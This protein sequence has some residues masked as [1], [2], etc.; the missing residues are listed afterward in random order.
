MG[1]SYGLNAN[2]LPFHSNRIIITHVDNESPI[3]QFGEC[4]QSSF[5]REGHRLRLHYE[6]LSFNRRLASDISYSYLE[7]TRWCLLVRL[8]PGARFRNS[9]NEGRSAGACH[10]TSFHLARQTGQIKFPWRTFEAM[11]E[12]WKVC[13]HS[14]V[15]SAWPIPGF[16]LSR[17]IAHVICKWKLPHYQKYQKLKPLKSTS[18]HSNHKHIIYYHFENE[19]FKC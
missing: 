16:I 9:L 1:P 10:G 6:D 18:Q 14:A 13:E 17:H 15:K 7:L 19:T 12:K 3:P 2:T 8:P 5:F 4:T 11:Q